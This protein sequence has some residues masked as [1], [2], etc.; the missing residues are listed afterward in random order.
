MIRHTFVALALL[1][2]FG[3]A[4][5]DL[6]SGHNSTGVATA[7]LGVANLLLLW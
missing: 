4:L 5:I 6:A 3:L 7:C 1:A 2:F